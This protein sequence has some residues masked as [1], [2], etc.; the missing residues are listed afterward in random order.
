MGAIMAKRLRFISRGSQALRRKREG[1]CVLFDDAP[2]L[3]AIK[4]IASHGAVLETAT[5]PAIGTAVELHHPEAGVL[6]AQVVERLKTGIRVAFKASDRAT[7]FAL[8][9]ITSDA[10][11]V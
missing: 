5:S 6:A 2:M 3:V 11:R 7:R 10:K 9:V 4:E 8:S 1:L